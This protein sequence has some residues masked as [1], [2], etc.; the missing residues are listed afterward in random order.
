MIRKVIV[1]FL[2]YK[3]QSS[4]EC[5]AKNDYWIECDASKVIN[6]SMWLNDSSKT[7]L[8]LIAFQN[9]KILSNQV[10]DRL[11][12]FVVSLDVSNNQDKMEWQTMN[13]INS[14]RGLFLLNMSFNQISIIREN[15]FDQLTEL[16]H[17][18]LSFN[19]I[20]YFEK[21]NSF[22]GLNSLRF[23]NLS[24]NKLTQIEE[25]NLNNM[26]SIRFIN[27]DFNKITRIRK[28]V[29]NKMTQLETLSFKFNRLKSIDKDAFK[30]TQ[31]NL[32]N[33]Y[34]NA[35]QLNELNRFVFEFY[36]VSCLDLSFNSIA[37]VRFNGKSFDFIHSIYLSNN[38]ISK[39][40][41]DS[42]RNAN[43]TRY[44]SLS[45]NKIK[46]INDKVFQELVELLELD[47]SNNLLE[48]LETKTFWFN[49]YLESLNVKNNKIKQITTIYVN[50]INLEN[51]LIIEIDLSIFD[52]IWNL[53]YFNFKQNPI[54]KIIGSLFN[55]ERNNVAEFEFDNKFFLDKL[56]TK[57]SEITTFYLNGL[58]IVTINKKM[59][60]YLNKLSAIYLKNNQIKSIENDS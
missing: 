20:F 2:L 52:D 28:Q 8:K 14:F 11:T 26:I 25:E 21:Q 29:F 38:N 9:V 27:L 50:K 44:L 34:I 33:V 40:E 42:F 46:I 60:Q 31:A 43:Q 58:R 23:L 5:Q 7:G 53:E 22:R 57:N 6:L 18:D 16:T 48:I 36:N 19:Q 59:F 49:V 10:F 35:N 30:G 54:K 51:N 39:L 55:E 17:L 24:R 1:Y 15:M 37:T 4:N 56:Y 45:N 12:S 3:I 13:R 32:K 41:D 47:L